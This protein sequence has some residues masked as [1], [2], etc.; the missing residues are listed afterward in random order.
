MDP[1]SCK[2]LRNITSFSRSATRLHLGLKAMNQQAL[3]IFTTISCVDNQLLVIEY[4]R[5]YA[6]FVFSVLCHETEGRG[7]G[8]LFDGSG[9][10]FFFILADICRGCLFDGGGGWFANS[11]IYVNTMYTIL[12]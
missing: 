3:Q 12:K 7:R 2:E 6:A 4:D 11:G 1:V 8:R 5:S 9:L 10:L